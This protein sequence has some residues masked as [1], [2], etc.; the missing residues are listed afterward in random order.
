MGTREMEIGKAWRTRDTRTARC[1]ARREL[2]LHKRQL[3]IQNDDNS[4]IRDA[5]TQRCLYPVAWCDGGY[6]G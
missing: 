5:C 6:G 2:L 3:T 1:E 4:P